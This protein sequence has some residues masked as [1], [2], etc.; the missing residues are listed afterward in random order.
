M[1]VS[2]LLESFFNQIPDPQKN[3]GTDEG[4]DDLTIPLWPEWSAGTDEAEQPATDDT[5]EKT[6]DDIP[7]KAALV[8]EY[9]EPGEPAG[10]SAEQKSKDNVHSV[11]VIS[12]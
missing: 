5:A 2:L 10:D 12:G 1:M 7:E 3:N 8:F 4:T 9:E 6:D 11:N